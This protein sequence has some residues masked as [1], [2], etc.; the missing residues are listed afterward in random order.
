MEEVVL[1]SDEKY[2]GKYVALRS[3]I[4]K[5]VVAF[6]D[7]PTNVMKTARGKGVQN[8]VLFFVPEHDMTLIY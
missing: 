7:D 1:V 8:P 5:E 2:E 6:G 4:N 3:F